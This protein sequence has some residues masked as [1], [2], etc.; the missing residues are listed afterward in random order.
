MSP[1]VFDFDKDRAILKTKGFTLID[2]TKKIKKLIDIKVIQNKVI[3]TN[4]GEF[5]YNKLV[6]II[7]WDEVCKRIRGLREAL[8][9][10]ND[11]PDGIQVFYKDTNMCFH[12][13]FP[14]NAIVWDG[15]LNSQKKITCEICC[16]DK[17]R[18]DMM[19]CP[20]CVYPC[21]REC[22]MKRYDLSNDPRCFGCRQPLVMAYEDDKQ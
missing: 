6:V 5:V 3:T 12:K 18:R 11:N 13:N 22:F 21:C 9:N 7:R 14:P 1:S 16:D 19:A 4:N 20:S 17:S 8:I 2:Y 15:F 10:F